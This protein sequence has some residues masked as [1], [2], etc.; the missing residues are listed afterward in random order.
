MQPAYR[1]SRALDKFPK[2][3]PVGGVAQQVEKIRAMWRPTTQVVP[4]TDEGG[5]D[6]SVLKTEEP[7]APVGA[8]RQQ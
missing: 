8:T 2:E 4:G 3:E 5:D 6:D 7:I 1:G